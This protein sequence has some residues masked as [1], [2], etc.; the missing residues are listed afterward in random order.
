MTSSTPS[1]APFVYE[2]LVSRWEG[3]REAAPVRHDEQQKTWLVTDH[4]NVTRVLADPAAFSSDFS[5]LTPTQED[6]EDFRQ[7]NFVGM[8]PPRHRTLRTLVSQ[9]FTPRVITDLEPRIHAITKDLLDAVDG[10]DQFDAVDA[11]A[12]PLPIIVIAELL[13][14]PAS[15]RGLF[16][17][18][19]AT[20]FGGDDLGE[21]LEMSDIERALE[22]I[23]PTVREMNS[24]F[25]DHIRHHRKNPGDNLTGK[26]VQAEA[27]G[28]RLS[29]QEIVGFVALLL[30]A[31]HVTTTALLGNALLCFDRHPDAAVSLRADPGLLS[32]T[33]DEVLRFLPPFPEL[34]RRT[35]REVELSGAIIPADTIVTAHLGAANRDRARF[36]DAES[37]DPARGSNPH[38]TFGHG[39]HFCF[40][41]PLA[42]MEARIALRMLFDRFPDIAIADR[43]GV[44]TQNPAVIVGARQLPLRVQRSPRRTAG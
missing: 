18:W 9:A 16:Q 40:G 39:I 20:L 25:L 24:Y 27:D 31:G 11:L 32:P 17:Q 42:R 29:D 15:D 37:F 6:F 28:T 8:D 22:A 26:L 33:I 34:G 23:A 19:A 41:A 12:Y 7:G 43:A 36:V 38:L 3:L 2:E 21:A 35:T 13:G 5:G 14:V 30:V 44:V 4:E 10:Q 1:E